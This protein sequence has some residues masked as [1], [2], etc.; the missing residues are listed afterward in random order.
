LD[1]LDVISLKGT[2]TLLEQR[3]IK[4]SHGFKL[5]R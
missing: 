2:K 4:S 1:I 5:S 3:Q